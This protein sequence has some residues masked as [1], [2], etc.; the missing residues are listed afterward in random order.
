MKTIFGAVVFV[1]LTSGSAFAADIAP[2]PYTKAPAVAPLY[3]WSGFYAGLNGGGAWGNGTGRFNS[4]S[5]PTFFTNIGGFNPFDLRA[6]H[7]GGFGGA[8]AGYNTLIGVWLIGLEAD[9]QGADIGRN[10]VVTFPGSGP[11]V[12]STTTS[13]DHLDW[14]GTVRGRLGYVADRVL[15]YGTGGLAYGGVNSSFSTVAS[16]PP[17]ETTIGTSSGT[18]VGWAAGAGIEW[19]FASN[20]ALKAEYLHLDLGYT[21]VVGIFLPTPINTITYRFDHQIDTVR[22]GINY[23]FGGPGLARY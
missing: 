1:A 8:Q 5:D 14:F 20:W 19:A 22:L 16:P 3:D 13:R 12:P 7:E 17:N 4:S 21:D 18:R 23:K 6:E 10:A 2:R 11:S 9:I 15:F